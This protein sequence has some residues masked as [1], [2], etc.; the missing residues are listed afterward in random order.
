VGLTNTLSQLQWQ[1]ALIKSLACCESDSAFDV[2]K[3]IIVPVHLTLS[4]QIV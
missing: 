3:T 4:G 2:I 1:E